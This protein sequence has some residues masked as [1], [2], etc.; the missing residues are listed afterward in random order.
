[1]SHEE[2]QTNKKISHE[3]AQETQKEV[4][5]GRASKSSITDEELA[6]AM[7]REREELEKTWA[8]PRGVWGWFTDTDHKAIAKRYIVTAFI[9]FLLGGIEAALLQHPG[10]VVPGVVRPHAP[11]RWQPLIDCRLDARAIGRFLGSRNLR[12]GVRPA[13]P[14]ARITG[15]FSL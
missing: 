15:Q 11:H 7:R 8:R 2:E 1:M 10:N 12:Q 9:F 13:F 4:P 14:D 5:T 3:E 6:E